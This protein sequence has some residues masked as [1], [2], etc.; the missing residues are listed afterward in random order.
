LRKKEGSQRSKLRYHS[1]REHCEKNSPLYNA[2]N[3]WLGQSVPWAH[4]AHLT[5]CLWMVAA[6]IQRGEVSLTRWLPYLPCR[7][8]QAQ[9]KQRRVSR[10]LHNSRINVHRLYK[11]LIQAALATW[12]E[13]CLYLS[14][15]T[16][17][18]WGEYCL[19]RLAV[20]YRGRALPVVWRVLKRRSASVAFRE[21]RE[22]LYQGANRLPQG[23][24]VVLLADRGFA[25]VKAMAAMSTELGWHYRIRLKR[26]AWIW[27]A[28]KGWRQ[29]KDF[30]LQRGEALCLHTVKLH[31]QEWY[32]PVHVALGYNNV[33]GEFWAIVSDE[34]T[35]LQTFREYG[36]RFDIEEAFLDDQSNGWNL[37]KS[38]LRSISALS[39]LWFILAVA[40]L[41]VTAQGV[42][43]V[44]SGHR[45]RVDPHWF[46]G[47]S[48]FRIGWDWVK[49]ALEQGWRLIHSVCFSRANDP[50]PAMASRKQHDDRTYRIEFKIRTYQYV[51]D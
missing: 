50:E 39:R 2:L 6:L 30:H 42:A 46:R 8:E 31:K 12:K 24:K 5:A 20:V 17:M 11:P 47:N 3:T 25:H 34:P 29:L 41:Y 9:S 10:W 26:N 7:G 1:N 15:D 19:I 18:Y 32:G 43:V 16:S 45:R 36:L 13:D 22:M 49:T 38:E 21:Y 28:G 23:I 48:Y 37:Q 51:P 33:N 27:R 44:E 14:L 40:T 4:R 35:N